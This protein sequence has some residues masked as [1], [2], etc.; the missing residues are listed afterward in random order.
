[1]WTILAALIRSPAPL[2]TGNDSPTLNVNIVVVVVVVVFVVFKVTCQRRLVQ[3]NSSVDQITIGSLSTTSST[4]HSQQQ[5]IQN[6]KQTNK[7]QQQQQHTT[8]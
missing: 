4:S 1:L 8:T 7:Q 6:N 5:H 3:L 2:W